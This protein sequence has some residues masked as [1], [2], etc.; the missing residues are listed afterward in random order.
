MPNILVSA[1]IASSRALGSALGQTVDRALGGAVA[2]FICPLLL[3]EV[4]HSLR[5]RRL[6]KSVRADEVPG[7]L[8]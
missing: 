1:V 2:V 3:T 5:S 4:G 6:M 8:W 7:V